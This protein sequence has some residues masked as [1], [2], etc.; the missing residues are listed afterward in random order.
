M[1]KRLPWILVGILSTV[2]ML[3]LLGATDIS[4]PNYGRYQLSSWS[5]DIGGDRA[6]V[7]A[8]IIDTATGETKTAYTRILDVKGTG[9]IL[10]ND[11]KT[12]FH[13]IK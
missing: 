3:F 13:S 6:A 12:T 10:K 11:L 4:A 1:N 9:I 7:G 2:L 5:T 8:F